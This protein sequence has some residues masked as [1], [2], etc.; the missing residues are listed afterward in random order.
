MYQTSR[1]YSHFPPRS[2][3]KTTAASLLFPAIHTTAA[4]A[5]L[6]MLFSL[7]A[8]LC[9]FGG[10]AAATHFRYGHYTWRPTTGNS[11]EFI[12]QN[13][14][15]RNGYNCINPATLAVLPCS[16]PD[17]QP[18][19]GDV[20]VEFIGAT[21]FNPGDGTAPVG[22]P[23]GPLMYL[24]T[25]IDPDNWLFALALDP[26]ALPTLKPTITHTYSTPGNYLAFTDSCCRISSLFAGNAHI[27]NPDGGYRVETVVNVGT[28]N[29]PPASTLPP[30]VVCPTDDVC[31]FFIPAGDANGDR[32]RF[33]LST[34]GEASSFGPFNQ[35][36]PPFAANSP[37]IDT[38]G[39]Y[40]WNTTGATLGPTGTNTLYSSQ[41]AIEDLDPSG[42]VK[43]KSALDF[44]IQLVPRIGVPPTLNLPPTITCPGTQ[45]LVVGDTLTITISAS[46]ADSGQTVQINVVGL[47]LGAMM[48]P[49]LPLV[50]NPVSSTFSWTPTADQV[51]TTVVIFTAR[52][53]TGQ[54]TLCAQ[55][56]NVLARGEAGRITGGGSITTA[57]GLKVTHGFQLHCDRANSPNNL[58]VNWGKG[59]RFHLDA[60]TMSTCSNDPDIRP[61]PPNASFDKCVGAGSGRYNG[62]PG[63]SVNFTVTDA[64]EPGVN[65]SLKLIIKDISGNVVLDAAGKLAHGNHQAHED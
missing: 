56:I 58:E 43:S 35:P 59:N 20:F 11:I 29:S 6:L 25:S 64:G 32:L 42:Q 9:L 2:A 26:A 49:A 36:G 38:Q 65:D 62:I 19:V 12:L 1:K 37:S 44:L 34:S 53:D 21:Q 41:V 8:V 5:Q 24:V 47:P 51:G 55:T 57:S 63:A 39:L 16:A 40:T 18:G 15:R 50:G 13:A 27:N 10:T 61:N 23:L 28:G 7:W 46:D 3:A 22:S 52:D 17:G 54:Q 4:R 14:F 33:R 31:Q 60:L 48:N 45:T 30:I